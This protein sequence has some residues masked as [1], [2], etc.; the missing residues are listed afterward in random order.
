[1]YFQDQ[2]FAKSNFKE[3]LG[4]KFQELNVRQGEVMALFKTEKT[5]NECYKIAFNEDDYVM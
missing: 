2:Y 3:S 4:E 1:M 5:R